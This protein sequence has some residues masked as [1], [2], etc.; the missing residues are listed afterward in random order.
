MSFDCVH[1]RGGVIALSIALGV[2]TASSDARELRVCADPNNFPFSDANGGGFE[3]KIVAIVARALE[4]DLTY[5]WWSQRRGYLRNTL[6]SGRCDLVPGTIARDGP[7]RYTAPYYRSSYV[8]V[9]RED[10]PRIASLD[11]PA[12]KSLV[13]GV[14]LVGDDGANTPPVEALGRRGLGGRLKGFPVYGNYERET[15]LAPIMEAVANREVDVALVWGPTAGYL[16]KRSAVPLRLTPVTPAIDGPTLPMMFDIAMGV[17]K[18][19]ESLRAAVNAALT[20]HRAEIDKVL[21]A[22]AIP[23]LDRFRQRDAN[24]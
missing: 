9:T 11:D 2:A 21:E 5:E 14:Q 24:P 16:A 22:Y 19:D 1:K 8:F 18:K 3:N 13:I 10:G 17:R 15:P 6:G 20:E 12:L 7:Y 4:A 23:R